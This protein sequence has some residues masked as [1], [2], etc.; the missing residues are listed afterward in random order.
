MQWC[1]YLWFYSKKIIW[2]IISIGNKFY[3]NR[4]FYRFR[5]CYPTLRKSN[6][7]KKV[8]ITTKK[9]GL[10]NNFSEK[11]STSIL[12]NTLITSGNSVRETKFWI[13]LNKSN[14]RFFSVL[15]CVCVTNQA[16]PLTNKCYRFHEFQLLSTNWFLSTLLLGSIWAK[17]STFMV[18]GHIKVLKLKIILFSCFVLIQGFADTS[19]RSKKVNCS[20][21]KLK[22]VQ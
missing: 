22:I 14:C 11:K 5:F 10:I 4:H 2:L 7:A 1:E 20:V 8:L 18:C 3:K 21:K 19:F 9:K 15:V 6:L 16:L 13:F 17:I 12:E